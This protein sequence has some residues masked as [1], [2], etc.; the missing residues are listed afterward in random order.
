M[1]VQSKIKQDIN[2]MEKMIEIVGERKEYHHTKQLKGN[3]MMNP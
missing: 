3:N 1:F 2:L